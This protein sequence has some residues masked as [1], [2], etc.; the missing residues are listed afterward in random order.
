MQ[1]NQ[2]DTHV[3]GMGLSLQTKAREVE[4]SQGVLCNRRQAK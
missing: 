4:L 2:S 1:R 3:L